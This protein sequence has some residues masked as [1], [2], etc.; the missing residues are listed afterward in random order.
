ME[1]NEIANKK[2]EKIDNK[3][4]EN[5][6]LKEIN[7]KICD[8]YDILKTKNKDLTSQI[9]EKNKEIEF[10]HEN[11]IKYNSKFKDL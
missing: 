6:K 8:E 7:I 1:K 4:E 2:L 9:N 3:L 11:E 10:I 5:N